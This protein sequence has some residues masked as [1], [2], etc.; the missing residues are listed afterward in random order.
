MDIINKKAE[1][2]FSTSVNAK[3]AFIRY[4]RGPE[5]S[6]DLEYVF[7]PPEA[8]GQNIADKLVRRALQE[9]KD[10]QVKIIPTCSYV[11]T[12][13]ARHPEESGMLLKD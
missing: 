9:A 3:E 7:V 10:E 8:R 1:Q 11:S 5:N 4:S 12:W 6:Y 13:F 2:K